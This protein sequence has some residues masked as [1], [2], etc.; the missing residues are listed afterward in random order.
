MSVRLSLIAVVLVG[1]RD[2]AKPA[3][4]ASASHP[5]RSSGSGI[6]RRRPELDT[7]I[8]AA[9]LEAYEAAHA[10]PAQDFDSE[11]EDP[12]WA[13]ATADEIRAAVSG[14]KV[15]CKTRKCQI[16][17]AGPPE[18]VIAKTE[19]LSTMPQHDSEDPFAQWMPMP[20]GHLRDGSLEVIVYAFFER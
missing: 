4:G 13:R 14:V 17:I 3:G 9:E 2:D 5:A 19:K 20:P 18:E 10:G 12:A 16:I 6:A 7:K 11:P 1:C 15:R 8:P